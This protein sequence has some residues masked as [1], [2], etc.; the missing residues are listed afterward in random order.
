MRAISAGLLLL[1]CSCGSGA[2][3]AL[4]VAQVDAAPLPVVVEPVM[5]GGGL[6]GSWSP[7]QA[8]DCNDRGPHKDYVDP[9]R[10]EGAR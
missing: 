8:A 2:D 9:A 3:T 6:G 10:T 7:C 1:A 4:G 5:G